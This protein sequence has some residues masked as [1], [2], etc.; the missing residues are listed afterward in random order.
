LFP[1]SNGEDFKVDDPALL[2]KC[3]MAEK[4]GLSTR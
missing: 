2:D 1:F 4:M 3:D